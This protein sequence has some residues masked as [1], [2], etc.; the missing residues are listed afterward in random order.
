MAACALVVAASGSFASEEWAFMV[1]QPF[2]L[3]NSITIGRVTYTGYYES[4][5]EVEMT[6]WENRVWH[7]DPSSKGV[8]NRATQE[9]LAFAAGLKVS[10]DAMRSWPSRSDTIY[11]TVDASRLGSPKRVTQWAD[12]GL[13]AAVV[14]CMRANAGQYA[15][16]VRF[17]AVRLEGRADF[18]RY[19]GV[20]GLEPYACGPVRRE[21]DGD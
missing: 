21:F 19:S 11:A 13:V 15:G 16:H 7:H 17:L 9:N 4:G 18:T 8:V 5:Q 12:S 1:Y 14:E 2:D 10:V 6:C 3:P 20:F